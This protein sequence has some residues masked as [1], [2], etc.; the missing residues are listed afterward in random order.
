MSSGVPVIDV[1]VVIAAGITAIGVIWRQVLKPANRIA[2]RVEEVLPVVMNIDTT[3]DNIAADSKEE[4]RVLSEYTHNSK[5]ALDGRLD[6]LSMSQQYFTEQ[7]AGFGAELS[8]VKTG[9]ED[10]RSEVAE[11]KQIV[12]RREEPR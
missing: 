12:D 8:E 4:L 10:V 9:L 11:V 3:L 7:L 1:I 6:A 5:H 2:H